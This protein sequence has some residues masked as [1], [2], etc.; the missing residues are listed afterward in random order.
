MS[1]AQK[2]LSSVDG[3]TNVVQ[4]ERER[5]NVEPIRVGL[6]KR[7]CH[8][9]LSLD[10]LALRIQ[11]DPSHLEESGARTAIIFAQSAYLEHA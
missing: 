3:I 7:L 4:Y 5:D 10:V 2:H 1:S 9:V 11:I 8:K 6:W